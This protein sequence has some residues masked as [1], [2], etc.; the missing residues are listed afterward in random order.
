MAKT[1]GKLVRTGTYTRVRKFGDEI[2]IAIGRDGTPIFL[3][4]RH[5]LMIAQLLKL[6]S[7]PVKIQ[8]VHKLYSKWNNL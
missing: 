8:I 1:E 5:R 7:I 6:K 2:R 3:G 4:G